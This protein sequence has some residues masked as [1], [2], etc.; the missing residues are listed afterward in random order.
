MC[1][2]LFPSLQAPH[3]FCL[4]WAEGWFIK[5]YEAAH[6]I[7]RTARALQTTQPGERFSDHTVALCQSASRLPLPLAPGPW[8]PETLTLVAPGEM[9]PPP[10]LPQNWFLWHILPYVALFPAQ[11]QFRVNCQSLTYSVIAGK[12]EKQV[13]ASTLE[14]QVS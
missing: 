2:R 8:T 13:G 7:F 5:V 3:P 6:R 10:L 11:V 4:V 9:P 1:V 12:A 14:R